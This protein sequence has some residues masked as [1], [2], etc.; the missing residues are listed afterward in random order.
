MRRQGRK[1]GMRGRKENEGGEGRKRARIGKVV[2]EG[3]KLR[4]GGWV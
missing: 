2:R 4:G 1:L 3:R